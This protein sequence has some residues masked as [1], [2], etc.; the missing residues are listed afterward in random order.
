MM[1]MDNCYDSV[2]TISVE[3]QLYLLTIPVAYFYILDPQY[4]FFAALIWT[5][6]QSV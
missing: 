4:G 3:M 1:G 5:G 6:K 2:W